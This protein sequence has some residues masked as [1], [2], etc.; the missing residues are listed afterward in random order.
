MKHG[1][2][3]DRPDGMTIAIGSI[4]QDGQSCVDA[5]RD[6]LVTTRTED[7]RGSAVRVDP[8]DLLCGNREHTVWVLDLRQSPDEETVGGAVK[9]SPLAAGDIG[10]ELEA[11]IDVR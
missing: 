2:V 9:R 6:L 1:R 3:A 4:D 7:R 8:A 5:G 10:A 11:I